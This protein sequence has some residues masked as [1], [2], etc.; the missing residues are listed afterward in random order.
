MNA[1]HVSRAHDERALRFG[2]AVENDDTG[3][4]LYARV[5]PPQSFWP[6][7]AR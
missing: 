2:S 1:P 7:K 3:K 5:A 6:G 4:V